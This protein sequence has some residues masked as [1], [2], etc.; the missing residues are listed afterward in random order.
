VQDGV[1]IEAQAPSF[2][3]RHFV[4]GCVNGVGQQKLRDAPVVI[5]L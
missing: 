3:A 4:V 5:G 2:F 1:G